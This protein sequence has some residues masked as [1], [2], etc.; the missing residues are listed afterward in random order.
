[1]PTLRPFWG[2]QLAR[3]IPAYRGV[4]VDSVLSW[5]TTR[6]VQALGQIAVRLPNSHCRQWL[7]LS[8]VKK[9]CED[10]TLAMSAPNDGSGHCT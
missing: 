10:S 6:T 9:D 2:F 1:M 3:S 5:L 4:S 8:S 7:S